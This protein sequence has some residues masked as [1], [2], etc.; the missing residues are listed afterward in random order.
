MNK[1]ILDTSIVI[2][3]LRGTSK[4]FKSI[5]KARLTKEA[6]IL[7]PSIVVVELFAGKEANN[8]KGRSAIEKTIKNLPVLGLSKKAAITAGDLIRKYL[9]I[10]DPFDFIIAAMAINENASIVTLNQK[11]FKEIKEVSL[12]DLNKLE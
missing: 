9:Q 6:E 12:F 8:R 10:P 7:L 5:E 3:H 2:A 4:H 1:L 11:H